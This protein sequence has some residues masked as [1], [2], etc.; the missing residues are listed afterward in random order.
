MRLLLGYEYNSTNIVNSGKFN[1]HTQKQ[2]FN[3]FNNLYFSLS[4][5]ILVDKDSLARRNWPPGK[6]S[7]RTALSSKCNTSSLKVNGALMISFIHLLSSGLMVHRSHV[8]IFQK[9]WM[10]EFLNKAFQ[11]ANAGIQVFVRK[12]QFSET[13]FTTQVTCILTSPDMSVNLLVLK[14]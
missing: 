7:F 13:G 3:S 5:K 4:S 10:F 11:V 6:G 1:F 9:G 14:G 2:L 12:C 8:D